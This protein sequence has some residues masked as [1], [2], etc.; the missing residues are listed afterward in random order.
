MPPAG[1]LAGLVL[2]AFAGTLIVIVSPTHRAFYFAR[3]GVG[4]PVSSP[5]RTLTVPGVTGLLRGATPEP[6]RMGV[7]A[8][9]KPNRLVPGADGRLRIPLADPMPVRLPA[10]GVP[11]SW[12]LKEF[13]GHAS[14]EL[15]RSE[16]GPALRLRSEQGSFLIY[17]D[18]VVDLG[19]FP[20]LSWSW[21]VTRLPAG[22][23]VRHAATDDQAAQVYVVFPRGLSPR[24]SSDVIG[25]VWDTTA[26]VGT[27]LPSRKAANVRII[28]LQSGAAELATWQRHERNVIQDYVALFGRQPPRVGSVA[29][30]VDANDTGSSSEAWI[31]ELAFSRLER[32]TPTPM[33][34]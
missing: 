11:S 5:S 1:V 6:P 20:L 23:D 10:Y 32:K 25:Y 3:S 4:A 2:M 15:Q 21:K 34:R 30:M 17:R 33:L 7:V 13:H 14:V 31:A 9:R 29:V 24:T 19:E 8:T 27:R 26:P 22:G 12:E 18:L 16:I 28:V